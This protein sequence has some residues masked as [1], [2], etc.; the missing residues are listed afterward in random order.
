M[1]FG[2]DAAPPETPTSTQAVC[3]TEIRRGASRALLLY[4][5]KTCSTLTLRDLAHQFAKGLKNTSRRK[6]IACIAQ[7][8]DSCS[9]LSSTTTPTMPRAAHCAKSNKQDT[10]EAQEFLVRFSAH[11]WGSAKTAT[12]QTLRFYISA[13]I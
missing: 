4:T 8:N 11:C 2:I 13:R 3:L 7:N 5:E 1:V 6:D 12:G 10:K 9:T